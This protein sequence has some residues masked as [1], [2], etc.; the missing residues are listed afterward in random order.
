M[1]QGTNKQEKPQI[2]SKFTKHLFLIAVIK[3]G[4]V[5]IPILYIE[6]RV[7][8]L[9]YIIIKCAVVLSFVYELSLDPEV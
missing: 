3:I 2:I 9:I 8:L 4:I 1:T 7:F 6:K 5:L